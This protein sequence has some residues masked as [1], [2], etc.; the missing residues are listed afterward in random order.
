MQLKEF[1]MPRIF[2]PIPGIA[3]GAVFASRAELSEAGVHRPLQGGISGS[4]NEGADSI[5]L[6]GGY[7][8]DQDLGDEVIYTGHGGRD[9]ETGRQI[10]D[11]T[12]TVGN[13]ALALNSTLGLPV[14]VIRGF[15]VHSP[16]APQAGY[17]YD[18]L[19]R[20]EEFWHE[21]GRSGF[22]VWR[23]RLVE[24]DGAK[25]VSQ[26]TSEQQSLSEPTAEVPGRRSTS[27]LRV[28]R[29]TAKAKEIKRLYDYSCQVCG[30]RLEG[31]AGPYAEAAHI[32]PLGAPHNGPDSSDNIICLCPNHHV[33]FDVG[34]IA[35][36]DDLSIIG[37]SGK[38]FVHS[39][40][41]LNLDF[42]RYHREHYGL[43]RLNIS[44]QTV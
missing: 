27:I 3:E 11:Q 5:V 19:Y 7:E 36:A 35:V 2:G 38:L 33:L 15:E 39:A 17:R 18:G 41:A 34:A 13:K 30:T 9:P 12:L 37:A 10:A 25:A 14:R 44:A 31:P 26:T 22:L 40:H 32:R 42:L 29:D 6:S 1:S 24:A 21:R 8:D 43:E 4:G 28:I 16:Y 23:Y 20:V